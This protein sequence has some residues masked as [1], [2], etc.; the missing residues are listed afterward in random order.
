M[1]KT[2]IYNLSCFIEFISYKLFYITNIIYHGY[3]INNNEHWFRRL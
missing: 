1:G 3:F 2:S